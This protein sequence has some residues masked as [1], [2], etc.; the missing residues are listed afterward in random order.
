[1]CILF[2]RENKSL[3]VIHAEKFSKLGLSHREQNP[4]NTPT[5]KKTPSR[6]RPIK[7]TGNGI[8]LEISVPV[9][10]H[11]LVSALLEPTHS[12]EH[13][14]SS[15]TNKHMNVKGR[16]QFTSLAIVRESTFQRFKPLFSESHFM[17]ILSVHT[18]KI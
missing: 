11:K 12:A 14:Y 18:V 3:Q 7:S 8:L 17:S 2:T 15:I 9:F 5:Q 10:Y 6:L 1:M 16:T 4:Q 13:H